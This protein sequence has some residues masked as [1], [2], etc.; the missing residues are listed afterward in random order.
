M[1]KEKKWKNYSQKCNSCKSRNYR[2]FFMEQI[3]QKIAAKSVGM[4]LNML[5]YIYPKKGF[6]LA[7]AFFSQPR[8]G[9][10]KK[11]ALPKMLLNA[12]HQLHQHNEHQFQTYTWKGNDDVI[13]L[14]H[15]WE[16]NSTRWKD[17]I[18]QL[19]KTE[20]TIIAIDAPAHGLSSGIEFNVPTYA[21]FI[22]VVSQK[23]KPKYIIGHSIGGTACT[24]FQYK[25][26][27]HYLEKMV[28]LGA[29]SDFT[30]ILQNYINILSLNSKIQTYLIAYIKERFNIIVDDFS[31]E[32]FL[33]N[34]KFP[35]IIAH[36]FQ[37]SVV[38][39]NEGKKLASS[40]KNAKF[41]ETTGLGHSMHNEYLYKTIVDFINE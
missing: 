1:K 30:L 6:P 31:G 10:L 33:Q 35:G 8:K 12:E 5:S 11:E 19:K 36:D 22:D 14:V 17:L 3:L 28:L 7:Y 40:W 18:I 37:D 16:S 27:N 4:Y 24:Y 21:E 25:Y 9:R 20:K 15:G 2:D 34:T 38:H 41:I 23:Y 32:K 39:F 29:P 26:Q 13:L